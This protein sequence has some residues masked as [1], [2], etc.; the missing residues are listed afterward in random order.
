MKI[1]ACF[2]LHSGDLEI[3]AALLALSLRR[4]WPANLELIGCIP[5]DASVGGVSEHCK[6]L[7]DGLE[8]RLVRT[9]NPIGS[10][11]PI[12]N[13]LLC[14]DVET[15]ADRMV[16]LDSD[17]L[18]LAPASEESLCAS[19]GQGFVAKPADL[20]TGGTNHSQWMAIYRACG[21]EFSGASMK[22]TV[23]RETM[24]PYF[25]AGVVGV[26]ANSDFGRL[27]SGCA[28]V[29][30]GLPDVPTKRPHLDQI[31]LPVAAAKSGMKTNILDE[32]WNYPAH[33]RPLP[34]DPPAICHYHWP[35]VIEREPALL[36]AVREFSADFPCIAKAMRREATWQ[37]LA[38]KVTKGQ[39]KPKSRR[40]PEG[41]IT[42]IPRSGTSYLCSLLDRLPSHVVINEPAEIFVPLTHQAPG[43]RIACYYRDLR[44]RI[45]DG[46]PVDN[47]TDA[48]RIIEDTAKMDVRTAV[49]I[50][51]QADDFTLWT[52]NTLAY[53]NRLPQLLDAMPKA[54]FVACI[55]HPVD[56]I[57]SWV[58]TFPHLRDADVER[59]PVG[60]PSDAFISDEQSEQLAAVSA[61]RNPHRRRAMLWSYL[62]NLILEH[63]D[64]L[65]VVRLEDLIEAPEEV[66]RNIAYAAAGRW[67][68]ASRKWL[69][70]RETV[71]PPHPADFDETSEVCAQP[72]AEFCYLMP[73]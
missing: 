45:I 61:C 36:D 26:D 56:T 6:R 69:R 32:R 29:V 60:N 40:L 58:R 53:L 4:H 39:Q 30:D 41:V 24:P 55:R 57:E 33:L 23:S 64:R 63:R 49:P 31:A 52:K 19:F 72:A 8:V 20:A 47:K 46:E 51:V 5:K 73:D 28:R 7:L 37:R 1:A 43:Q 48:G 54:T 10:A 34:A 38:S 14:L 62:A 25:N 16:F 11:Y 21:A 70:P 15:K 71:R 68:P 66:G 13:K 2:C 12:G 17:I 65:V 3:K 50:S 42:G 59:F 18:A 44:R 27:W 67:L 35:E 22:A 9:A